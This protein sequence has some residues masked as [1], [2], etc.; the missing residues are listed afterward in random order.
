M[1]AAASLRGMV[2][3]ERIGVVGSV[4]GWVWLRA[5]T[6]QRAWWLRARERER[7]RETTVLR[8]QILRR[9]ADPLHQ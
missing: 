7:E 1:D 5:A 8:F 6:S 2:G 4:G 9:A 3:G